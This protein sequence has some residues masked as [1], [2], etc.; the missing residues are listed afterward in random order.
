MDYVR[1][2]LKEKNIQKLPRLVKRPKNK[3][4]GSLEESCESLIIGT[5]DGREERRRYSPCRYI[6]RPLMI[7]QNLELFRMN[8]G[9]LHGVPQEFR[10]W[11]SETRRLHCGHLLKSSLRTL[12]ICDF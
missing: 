9:R 12:K 11:K 3:Q 5:A 7:M 6:G 10:K 1:E 8:S 2:D 4:K